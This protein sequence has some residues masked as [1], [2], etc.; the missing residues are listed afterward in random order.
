MHYIDEIIIRLAIRVLKKW[1]GADCITR[2]VVEMPELVGH[3]ELRC[4]S[5]RAAETIDFLEEALDLI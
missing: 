1:Y 3:P 2:D 5:C 4:A